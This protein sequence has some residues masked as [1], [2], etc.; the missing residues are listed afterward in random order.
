MLKK[1]FIHPFFQVLLY[2]TFSIGALL[3][4]FTPDVPLLSWSENYGFQIMLFYLLTGF[5][6]LLSNLPRWMFISFACCAG[7]CIFLK[8]ESTGP[9]FDHLSKEES[10]SIGHFNLK[11]ST[12][13]L[14]VSLAVIQEINADLISIHHINLE[15]LC[16]IE[17][18]LNKQYP[19][20]EIAPFE[21]K[22]DFR[23]GI[24]S[25]WP[26]AYV[27]TFHSMNTPQIIGCINWKEED[28]CF[29]DLQSPE[30]IS[31]N[32]T[33]LQKHFDTVSKKSKAIHSPLITMGEFDLAPWSREIKRLNKEENLKVSDRG[34]RPSLP[35]GELNL[36]TPQLQQILY[37]KEFICTDFQTI[38]SPVSG[39]FGI[40]GSYQLN[41]PLYELSQ[42]VR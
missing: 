17:S 28:I 26:I 29:I 6:F 12:P 1:V 7:L 10:I 3:V 18:Q 23:T 30:G 8:Q 20:S 35:D 33:S 42:V 24:L 16:E 22:N 41:Q 15:Q 25:K 34:P 32:S 40:L 36:F 19:F 11:K 13:P 2:A 4:I 27:D 14:E 21:S 5:V 38:S 9:F 31:H 39:Q 37:S